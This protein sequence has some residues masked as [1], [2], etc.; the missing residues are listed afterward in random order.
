[1]F[2]GLTL[3]MFFRRSSDAKVSGL[4]SPE[5]VA[6]R[7]SYTQLEAPE[8]HEQLALLISAIAVMELVAEPEFQAVNGNLN[9]P[10]RRKLVK[11]ML[12]HQLARQGF[13]DTTLRVSLAWYV[14]QLF[15]RYALGP[16]GYMSRQQICRECGSYL[17]AQFITTDKADVCAFLKNE[18]ID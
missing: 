4:I 6:E 17:D 2:V 5:A 13:S 8:V 18:P 9:P 3:F 14:Y 15:E 11:G 12:A 1:M 10:E 16:G 7:K